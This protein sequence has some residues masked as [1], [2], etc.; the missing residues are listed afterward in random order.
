MTREPST[1]ITPNPASASTKRRRF[2]VL[3][4]H[5]APDIAPTGRVMTQLV[6]EWVALGH[7]V[8]VITALPWYR[9]HRVEPGWRGRLVRRDRTA[10]GTNRPRQPGSTRWSRYHGKAVIT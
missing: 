5:F 4:P 7:E 9:D 3:C 10:W 6:D 2:I 8:H 1:P